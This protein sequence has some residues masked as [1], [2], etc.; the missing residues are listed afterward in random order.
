MFEGLF[1]FQGFSFKDSLGAILNNSYLWRKILILISLTCLVPSYVT[2]S[3]FLLSWEKVKEGIL[4]NVSYL[5]CNK[6]GLCLCS[7][8]IWAQGHIGCNHFHIWGPWLHT[9]DHRVSWAIFLYNIPHVKILIN[10]KNLHERTP[11]S[12]VVPLKKRRGLLEAHP[13]QNHHHLWDS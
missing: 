12:N 9:F 5:N 6:E 4:S 8:W 2:M 13:K 11:M 10:N 3:L 1:L 7:S